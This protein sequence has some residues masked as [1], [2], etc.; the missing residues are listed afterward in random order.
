MRN[1]KVGNW[2][3]LFIP[4]GNDFAVV[5]QE[6]ASSQR[7]R[8]RNFEPTENRCCARTLF[9]LDITPGTDDWR[10]IRF[11]IVS[12][13]SRAA[14]FFARFLDLFPRATDFANPYGHRRPR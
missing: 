10:Y 5:G 14:P 12:L 4:E 3:R 8:K 7:V 1:T 6:S 13:Q 9:H 11:K 2:F